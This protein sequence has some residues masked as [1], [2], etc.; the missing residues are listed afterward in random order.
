[1]AV[2]LATAYVPILPSM[3]GMERELNK[4]LTPIA[5]RAAKNAGNSSG[6]AF[7]TAF[8]GAGKASGALFKDLGRAASQALNIAPLTAT[9]TAG[10]RSADAATSQT[11]GRMGSLGGAVSRLHSGL[12]AL[13]GRVTQAAAPARTFGQAFSTSFQTAGTAQQ[14]FANGFGRI[15][16]A[17]GRVASKVSAPLANFVAGARDA[18]TAASSF[19]GRMGSLGGAFTT[20]RSAAGT[21][22]TSMGNAFSGL[23]PHINNL[24]GSIVSMGLTAGKTLTGIAAGVAGIALTGGVNRALQIENAEAKLTG[25]GNSAGDVDQI[26]TNALASVKGTSFGLNE[27]A[28][29]AASAVA[30]GIKPGAELEGVLKTV[31]N[32]AAI[33]GTD[34]ASMGSIFNK[35]A[36]TGHLQGD[37]LMQLSDAGV[38]ALSFLA[39]ETG[40]TSAEVSDMV[41]KGKIDFATFAS[42]MQHGVGDAAAQMGKTTTGSFKNMLAALSRLGAGAAEP[43]LPLVTGMFNG[44]TTLIDQM[45]ERVKPVF[46]ELAGG[47]RAFG[48][49]FH[50][51]D[52]DITSSG[53]P[54]LMEAIAFKVRMAYDAVESF[55][56]GLS[57]GQWATIGGGVGII[58]SKLLSGALASGKLAEKFKILAPLLGKLSGAFKFLGGP[59]GLVISLIASAVAGSSELQGAI[60]NVFGSLMELGGG[61]LSTLMPVFENLMNTAG[62]GLTAIFGQIV[63][64]VGQLLLAIM[65]VVQTLIDQLAPVIMTLIG[66]L[67]PPLVQIFSALVGVVMTLLPPILGIVTTVVSLLVPV[68]NVLIQIIAGLATFLITVLATA[69][70]W[71]VDTVFPALG[72]AVQSVGGFFTWLWQEVVVPAWGGIQTA[73]QAVGDWFTL[74]LVPFFQAALAVLGAV[75]SWLKTTIIDPVWYGIKF[76]IAMIA[77]IL[78]TIWQG[79]VWAVQTFLAPVFTWLYENIIKPVWSWIQI[80]IQAVG[81]WFSTVLVPAFQLALHWLGDIFTWLYENIVRPVWGWIQTAIQA[82]GSWFS[83]VLVPF[84]RAAMGVLADAFR[85]LY[86]SVIRPV[87]GAIKW[88]IEMAWIG[89]QAIWNAIKWYINNVLSPVFHWLLDSV[90]RP[91]WDGIGT[92]IKWVWE[93]VVSP[94]WEALKG[95]IGAVADAFKTG[96]DNIR[97][98]WNGLKEA[99]KVPVKWVIDTVINGGIVKSFNSIAKV[100]GVK[101]LA[102]F[103]PDGFASGGYTGD[104]SKYQPAGVVHGGEFVVD[105]ESTRKLRRERPGFLESLN[106]AGNAGSDMNRRTV[107]RGGKLVE[108]LASVPPHGP[109]GGLWG[110]LQ[111]SAAKAGHFYVPKQNFMGVDTEAAARAWM[112]RSALDVRMGNGS[113]GIRSFQTGGNGGW[114]FYSGNSIWMQPSVPQNRRKGVLVHE[115][116]H[117]LGLAHTAARDPTSVMDHFMTGGDW[118]HVGDYQALVDI[119]GKPGENVKTY[120]DPGSDD[121]GGILNPFEGLADSLFGKFKE[122][123]PAAGQWAEMAWGTG[124]HLISEAMGWVGQKIADVGGWVKDKVADAGNR[125]KVTAWITEALTRTGHLSPGNISA[126]VNRAFKESNG[127]P[128][129]VNNWDSNAQKGDPSRGLMQVVGSTFQQY[130][131]PG[132]GNILDPVDNAIAAIRYTLARYGDLQK[133]WG[134]SGGYF[135]GGLV[136]ETTLF[137]GGG[138]LGQNPAGAAQ[139]VAHRMTKPDA[140][141]TNQEFHDFHDIALAVKDGTAG[142]GGAVQIGSVHGY[143][144]EEVADA[145]TRLMREEE[146]L[147]ATV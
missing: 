79:I 144:A 143:T 42:A 116:G 132:H 59:W 65:P 75:F 126:G 48:A 142:A 108:G 134:L 61:L 17:A 52:G 18:D 11:T 20:A 35:V 96:V 107:T 129:A 55:L 63:D 139:L 81:T 15:G 125:V 14:N 47:I 72:I 77:A 34:M 135:N 71:I 146:A 140:V 30:A 68:L 16:A 70:T 114:G 27:A 37:E 103:H 147:H 131:M 32:T 13:A 29:T 118:P 51:A 50:Y 141:L 64:A 106:T 69:I 45:T 100:I 5:D 57:G 24:S 19:S 31:S 82:V 73:I 9:F 40:K 22:R 2:E 86:D 112:G 10:M 99:A 33:A 58:A 104:G 124:K 98:W 113:P 101:E 6:A 110:N 54:G 41:S 93:H 123:F 21:F 91:V 60:G 127:D 84:F 49:A 138:W 145:I 119:Y 117:A 36:A 46:T 90:I 76:T 74:T 23:V 95:G 8:S 3:R 115:L 80:A 130:M 92:A 83:N 97:K 105:R 121:G 7:A 89:I 94:T 136:P 4:Q 28:T 109:T 44:L 56:S 120:G 85:W 102:E 26:M 25:L 78:M 66:S 111:I 133:G 43:F 128:N 12:G 137:D 1:M 53:F 39:K 62:P 67:L 122:K 38:P 87:W 88:A